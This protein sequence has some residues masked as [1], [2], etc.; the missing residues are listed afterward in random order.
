MH[1]TCNCLI[2]KQ[3]L[4]FPW[5]SANLSSFVGYLIKKFL[6]LRIEGANE[7]ITHNQTWFPLCK[8]QHLIITTLSMYDCKLSLYDWLH[9]MLVEKPVLDKNIEI[10]WRNSVLFHKIRF[11]NKESTFI[12]AENIKKKNNSVCISWKHVNFYHFFKP[13]SAWFL[14]YTTLSAKLSIIQITICVYQVCIMIVI[15]N[16]KIK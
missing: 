7:T 10:I 11:L 6:Q 8:Y 9:K 3:V 15:T 1:L 13:F 5:R 12:S 16:L 14:S 2:H 4:K